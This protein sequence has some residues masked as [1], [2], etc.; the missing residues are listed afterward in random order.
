MPK[1]DL[2]DRAMPMMMSLDKLTKAERWCSGQDNLDAE[3][4]LK[5]SSN[6]TIMALIKS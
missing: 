6:K 1:V 4:M 5:C 3:H 2:L